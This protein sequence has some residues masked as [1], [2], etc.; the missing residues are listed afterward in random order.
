VIGHEEVEQEH[1]NWMDGLNEDMKLELMED[2]EACANFF[3]PVIVPVR[4]SLM[5]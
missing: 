2:T 5:S 4:P 1:S 3:I